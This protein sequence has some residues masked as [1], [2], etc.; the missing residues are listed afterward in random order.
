MK[1]LQSMMLKRKFNRKG[2]RNVHDLQHFNKKKEEL[3][4]NVE[5]KINMYTCGPTVYHYAH[6]GIL[7]A[8]L[9]KMMLEK[10]LR[11]SRS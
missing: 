4:P 8:T 9:W 6:I 3:I 7:E 1:L 2:N 5:G 10:A 11:Y